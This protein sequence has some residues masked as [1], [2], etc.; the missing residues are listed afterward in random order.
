MRGSSWTVPWTAINFDPDENQF[1]GRPPLPNPSKPGSGLDR[2]SA[3]AHALDSRDRAIW[4]LGTI[5]TIRGDHWHSV[6][7][8][9]RTQRVSNRLDSLKRVG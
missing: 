3:A 7:Q 8:C 4:A 2:R 6:D 9:M 5:G 1:T